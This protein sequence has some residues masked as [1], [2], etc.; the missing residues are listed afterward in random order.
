M[1]RCAMDAIRRRFTIDEYRVIESRITRRD[2]PRELLAA[3][4]DCR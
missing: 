3:V 4:N 2:V 1:C